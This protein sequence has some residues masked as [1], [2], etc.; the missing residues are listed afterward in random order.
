M[1]KLPPTTPTEMAKAERSIIEAEHDLA[2]ATAA[3]R[4]ARHALRTHA[5]GTAVTKLGQAANCASDAS[6]ACL[7]AA[8]LLF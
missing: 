6:F 2:L 1:T 8:R 5:Q 7:N 3:M 4:A